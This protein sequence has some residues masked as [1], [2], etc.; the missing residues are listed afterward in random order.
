MPQNNDFFNSSKKRIVITGL[1]TICSLGHNSQDVWNGICEGKNG[2]GPITSFDTERLAIKIAGEVSNYSSSSYFSHKQSKRL[3]RFSEF[4]VIASREAV[5]DSNLSSSDLE[6]AA[7]IVGTGIG[8]EVARDEASQRLYQ[9]N[10]P[11]AHPFT[12]PRI[13][14]SAVASHISMEHGIHGFTF[15]I[16]SACSSSNHAII[17]S[18]MMIQSGHIEVAITGG[19]EACLTL[20]ALL[21]WEAVSVLDSEACRPFSL[22]RK[23]LVLGEGAGILVLESLD[24][25]LKRNAKIYAE[26]MGWGVSADAEDLLHPSE[27]RIAQTMSQAL[28]SAGVSPNEVDYINA[29]GSGTVTNDVTETRAIHKVFGSHASKLKVSSTKSMHGH[30]LGATGALELIVTTLAIQHSI[31]PPTINYQSPDPKCNLDYIPNEAQSGS[32][33]VALSSSFAFGGLNAVVVLGKLK[34]V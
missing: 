13:M 8:G 21:A 12:V 10:I 24:H 29:H 25:A 28:N 30:A 20:G 17:Q 3:D 19:A 32:I 14:P 18:A 9:H 15:S 6:N 33:S 7:V 34:Q 11:R 2:I 4:G 23:G 16:S 27:K 1:G 31:L 5:V 22:E 26:I